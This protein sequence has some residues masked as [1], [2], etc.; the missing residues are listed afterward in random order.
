MA[1]GLWIDVDRL[2]ADD[3]R[4]LLGVVAYHHWRSN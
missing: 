1:G 2:W 3:N 4:A